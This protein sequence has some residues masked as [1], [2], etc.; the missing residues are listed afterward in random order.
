[1]QVLI[2]SSN[3]PN[4]DCE[5]CDAAPVKR[6]EVAADAVWVMP[7]AVGLV[8]FVIPIGSELATLANVEL[9]DSVPLFVAELTPGVVV[10][11]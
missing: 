1:M 5:A 10:G 6:P 3:P 9:P 2:V 8:F 11:L 4:G 7:E